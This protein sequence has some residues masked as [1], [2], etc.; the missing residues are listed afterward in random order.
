MGCL[1]S[2]DQPEYKRPMSAIKLRRGGSNHP[3]WYLAELA[4]LKQIRRTPPYAGGEG[5]NRPPPPVPVACTRPMRCPCWPQA[6]S[7]R[8]HDQVAP[9]ALS[10]KACKNLG[11]VLNWRLSSQEP[12]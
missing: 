9:G 5:P 3:V 1:S 7:S 2:T 8:L 12:T 6:A 10:L 11:T 4:K